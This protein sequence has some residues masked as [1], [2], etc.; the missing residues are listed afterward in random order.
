MFA[1][2]AMACSTAPATREPPRFDVLPKGPVHSAMWQLA[3]FSAE[4]DHQLRLP[5]EQI[6]HPKVIRMLEGM[7]K[8]AARLNEDELRSQHPL[9]DTNAQELLFD[10]RHALEAAR[11]EPPNYYLAGVVSG[12]CIYCHAPEGG[13]QTQ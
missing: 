8:A 2:S 12:S 3:G 4:L 5:P 7:Q 10:V 11:V 1:L 13:L 9:L 6:D